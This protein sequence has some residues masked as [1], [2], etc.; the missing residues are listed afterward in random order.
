MMIQE[1]ERYRID[2]TTKI[3]A[4]LIEF[5]DVPIND[6]RNQMKSTIEGI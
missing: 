5:F 6:D 4:R 1:I 2:V 3:M